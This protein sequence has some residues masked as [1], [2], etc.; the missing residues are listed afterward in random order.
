MNLVTIDLEIN[1]AA[2]PLELSELRANNEFDRIRA[3][4]K[5]DSL[6]QACINHLAPEQAETVADHLYNWEIGDPK[7]KAIAAYYR[8]SRY[9]AIGNLEKARE[10]YLE[11]PDD[12]YFSYFAKLCIEELDSKKASQAIGDAT[13][14]S[15]EIEIR[16]G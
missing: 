3:D 16:K 4:S 7:C 14:F 15:G 9:E 12:G 1:L 8:A 5:A 10:L 6:I 13:N 11:V 2:F